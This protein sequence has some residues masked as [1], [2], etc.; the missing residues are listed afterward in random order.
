MARLHIHQTARLGTLG[1]RTVNDLAAEL[2][3]M[4]IENNLRRKLQDN[5]KRLR[6]MGT[7][8]GRRHAMSLPVRGQ[9]TRTQVLYH[10]FLLVRHPA[11]HSSRSLRPESLTKLPAEVDSVKCLVLCKNIFNS[12]HWAA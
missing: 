9:N 1:H 3:N 4:T 10:A 6:D 11:H 8:R 7:Y 12:S 5:I 2:Q